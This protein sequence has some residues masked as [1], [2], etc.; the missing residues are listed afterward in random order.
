MGRG[1]LVIALSK[2]LMG[3][4]LGA[5]ISLQNLPGKWKENFEALFSESM[6]RLLVTVDPKKAL[7]FEKLM[8]GNMIANLG[9]ITAQRQLLIKDKNDKAIINVKLSDTLRAYKSTFKDY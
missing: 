1:G 9:K 6:G 3:G 4:Y 7:R 5:K 8:K 2:M